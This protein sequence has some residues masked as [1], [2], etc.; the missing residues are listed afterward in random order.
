M[1]RK[2]KEKRWNKAHKSVTFPKKMGKE[3]CPPKMV[4]DS[5][6]FVVSGGWKMHKVSDLG[7]SEASFA[8]LA[9]TSRQVVFAV[10]K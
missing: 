5:E 2:E 1:A 3:N 4:S 6:F 7:R 8:K 10:Y 9:N